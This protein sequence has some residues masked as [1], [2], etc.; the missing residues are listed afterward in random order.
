MKNSSKAIALFFIGVVLM[1]LYNLLMAFLFPNADHEKIGGTIL[2]YA[3]LIIFVVAIVVA[4][5][6]KKRS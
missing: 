5:I 2:F 1:M 4:I 6:V 3:I